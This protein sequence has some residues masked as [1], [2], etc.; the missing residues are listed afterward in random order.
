[1]IIIVKAILRECIPRSIVPVNPNGFVLLNSE[2]H[3]TPR[4][5]PGTGTSPSSYTCR[6]MENLR[7]TESIATP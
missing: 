1:M 4:A 2:P 6:Y 7:I 5:W 3:H